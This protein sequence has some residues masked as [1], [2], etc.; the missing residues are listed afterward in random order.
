[1]RAKGYLELLLHIITLLQ[2]L[3]GLHTPNI[4]IGE[5]H[6]FFERT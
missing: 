3:P 2:L 1:M 4:S 6:N 5:N